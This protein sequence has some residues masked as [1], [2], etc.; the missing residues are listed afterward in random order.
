MDEFTTLLRACEP[1]A[2]D[3]LVVA[4]F[5]ECC[6]AAK[7]ADPLLVEGDEAISP[8]IFATVC[9]RYG[10]EARADMGKALGI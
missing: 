10:I 3:D 9:E 7:A 4:A 2:S 6:D 1:T 5:I 8:H